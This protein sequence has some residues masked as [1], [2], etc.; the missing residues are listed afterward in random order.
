M[1]LIEN[2]L[3]PLSNEE[4]VT[5]LLLEQFG[6][7]AT[8]STISHQL[9]SNPHYPSLAAVN[10]VLA[11]YGIECAAVK[12]QDKQSLNQ[13]SALFIAQV[14]TSNQQKFFALVYH[15]T[16]DAVDWFNPITHHREQIPCKSFFDMFTGYA[17]FFD[18]TDAKDE[19][20]YTLNRKA[21]RVRLV[22]ESCFILFLPAIA[23]ISLVCT[24]P[25]DEGLSWPLTSFMILSIAGY[26]MGLL[27]ILYETNEYSP[28]L[29]KICGLTKKTNCAAVLYSKGS[30]LWGIPWSIIGTSYFGGILL[31]VIV[32]PSEIDML[33][34]VAY[35]HI[36][37]LTYVVYSIYYQFLTVRLWCPLCLVVQ[38]IIL[39]LFVSF[40]L[41]DKYSYPFII[42]VSTIIPLLSCIFLSFV[43]LYLLWQL[44]RQSKA[45]HYYEHSLLRIK[46][47][48][49]VFSTLL[50]KNPKIN[51]PTYGFGIV[52][53]NPDGS[54]HIIKVC[55]PY[56]SHCADAQPVLQHIVDGNP[57]V[58]LQII[59]AVD[60]SSSYYQETPIDHFL[61][62]YDEGADMESILTDWY[63]DPQKDPEAF[64]KKYPV[65]RVNT[66]Q[67][68]DNAERMSQFCNQVHIIGTP[69][70][71]INGYQLP[72]IY[73]VQELEYCI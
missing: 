56:C 16:A 21:E 32:S 65:V 64:K 57:E 1:N 18:E 28:M 48:K 13:M 63:A 3:R 59:F 27:L 68:R 12:V 34:S 17:M 49:E 7:K 73:R 24:I 20:N 15:L 51:V 33:H 23:I 47:D 30:R 9:Q 26:F 36:L 22:L 53:G 29:H 8:R 50:H 70:I 43:A 52:I 58:K 62:L 72:D 39:L 19:A 61:S 45:R 71:F 35:L 54:V 60:P 69:T 41:S 66:T 44:S 4:E 55:N 40:Y 37:A 6:V 46:Y 14:E 11:I 31:A 10:D 67:N 2:I 38:T 42:N 25:T 5:C